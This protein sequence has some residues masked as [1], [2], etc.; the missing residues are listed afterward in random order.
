MLKILSRHSLRKTAL[1]LALIRKQ[2]QERVNRPQLCEPTDKH[3]LDSQV[4]RTA[5]QIAIAIAFAGSPQTSR[6]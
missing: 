5:P 3:H 2:L 1:L 4:K 6:E